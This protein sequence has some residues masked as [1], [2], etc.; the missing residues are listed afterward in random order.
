MTQDFNNI[1]AGLNIPTQIPLNIK[2]NII[3]EA[4]LAYLGLSNNLAYTYHDKLI[5]NCL[6]EGTRY[7]WREV[8]I[9]EENSGLVP[10]DFTYPSNIIVYGIDYSNRKFNFFKLPSLENTYSIAN[11]GT[12]ENIYKDTTIVLNNTQFNLKKLHSDTL[13]VTTSVD[14][15]TVNIEQTDSGLPMFIVNSSYIGTE[16]LGTQTKPFKD[17]PQALV[18]YVGSGTNIS[19]ENDGVQIQ[20]QKGVGYNFTGNFVYKNLNI[21]FDN[22]LVNTNPLVGDYVLDYDSIAD[23]SSSIKISLVNGARLNCSKKFIRTKGNTTASPS[24]FKSIEVYG[25]GTGAIYNVPDTSVISPS[26]KALFEVNSTDTIGYNSDA[27]LNI[28]NVVLASPNSPIYIKGGNQGMILTNCKIEYGTTNI[29]E[30]N[31]ETSPFNQTGGTIVENGNILTVYQITG[32]NV[33]KIYR[34]SNTSSF[35]LQEDFKIQGGVFEYIFSNETGASYPKLDI[36]N[37]RVTNIVNT[38]FAYSSVVWNDVLL[39]SSTLNSGII[40]Y[41]KVKLTS[42]A[43]NLINGKV[44]ETLP[45]YD[46]RAAAVVAGLFSGCKFINTGGVVSPTTGWF[47]DIVI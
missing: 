40:D 5:V 11:I 15:N 31:I 20:V 21:K 44:V 22:A 23:I 12:G 18:A 16:E 27:V 33:N 39:R 1:P 6:E 25:D 3:N 42:S 4:T 37:L 17:I 19:P 45:Q 14:G 28:N 7:I 9:G 35:L 13:V 36:L 29:A 38:S 34:I 32:A 2:E 30:I 24:I 10:I 8:E 26:T 41:T 47:I 46:N 43:I